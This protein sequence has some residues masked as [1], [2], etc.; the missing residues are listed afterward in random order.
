MISS[1][2]VLCPPPGR[3]PCLSHLGVPRPWHRG[4]APYTAQK[5]PRAQVRKSTS[6][7]GCRD[8]GLGHLRL[9]LSSEGSEPE[10]GCR[11]CR[12]GWIWGSDHR[13]RVPT[14]VPM[15]TVSGRAPAQNE[16][17]ASGLNPAGT[18]VGTGLARATCSPRFRSPRGAAAAGTHR[19]GRLPW[20]PS[21][22][23]S[24]VFGVLTG[25]PDSTEHL[26][27]GSLLSLSAGI[28][29]AS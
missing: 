29:G 6:G 7:W 20:K 26:G 22:S 17:P 28:Q 13:Q 15:G 18:G 1:R 8:E 14:A 3:G 5:A 4:H 25:R 16:Q 11:N 27:P 19:V 23:P 24:L 10:N 21:A 12:A 9:N 2:S